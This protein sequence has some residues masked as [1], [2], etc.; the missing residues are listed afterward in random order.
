MLLETVFN[1]L[2]ARNL[3]NLSF[4]YSFVCVFVMT[5]GSQAWRLAKLRLPNRPGAPDGRF[6]N[7]L[8]LFYEL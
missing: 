1:A 7:P 5:N 8:D 6:P 4:L 3:S 2:V